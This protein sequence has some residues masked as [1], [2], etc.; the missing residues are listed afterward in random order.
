MDLEDLKNELREELDLVFHEEIAE[1]I[2]ENYKDEELN[3]YKTWGFKEDPFKTRPLPPDD[4]GEMLLVGREKEIQKISRRLMTTEK[5]I[6]LEGMNGIGK[7]SLINVANYKCFNSSMAKGF[8]PILLPCLTRFQLEA[9]EDVESFLDRLFVALANTLISHEEPMK[10]RGHSSLP[11]AT[12]VR[13]FLA[14]PEGRSLRFSVG[15]VSYAKVP[16]GASFL[17]T[18]LRTHVRDWLTQL[19]PNHNWGGVVCVLDNIEI[20]KSA[21]KARA[22]LEKIR[23]PVLSMPGVRWVMCGSWGI[24]R[25]IASSSRLAGI[26]HKPIEVK[27][28]PNALRILKSRVSVFGV[29]ANCYLPIL[30]RDFLMLCQILDG[31]I[32]YTLDN[33]GEYCLWIA[34]ELDERPESDSAKGRR[35]RQ[36]INE[37]SREEYKLLE[38]KL[39]SFAWM[40]FDAAVK[41]S[42]EFSRSDFE[43]MIYRYGYE[44]S[45]EE[46][47]LR[48]GVRQLLE[49]SLL[50]CNEDDRDSKRKNH[51]VTPRGW[52]VR[53]ARDRALKASDSHR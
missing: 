10:S 6:T 40:V 49:Y 43:T 41:Q 39:D 34:E 47:L 5:I 19:F 7:T 14:S 27:E 24:I 4:S 46:E 33:L 31:N 20:L 48:N 16:K 25:G 18:G 38:A 1:R 29:D 21:P 3:F 22:F 2:R 45:L 35:F 51:Y 36:W 28:V 12:E 8:G 26:L 52:L 53:Y 17:R 9:E 50:G 37:S 32:R 44:D 30:D 23:D 42:G 13:N 11:N 15:P